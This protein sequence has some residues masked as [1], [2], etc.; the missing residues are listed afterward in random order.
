MSKITPN[1]ILIKA[2]GSYKKNFNQ[3]LSKQKFFNE[4]ALKEDT[5]KF[6]LLEIETKGPWHG[7]K[8]MQISASKMFTI[9][10][11]STTS[12][13]KITERNTVV[14]I[15][16]TYKIADKEL[17]TFLELLQ[18]SQITK[19]QKA[20]QAILDKTQVDLI[21]KRNN[22]TYNFQD[23]NIRNAQLPL[24]NY[25]EELEKR[26]INKPED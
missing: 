2:H 7:Y 9:I 6:E 8:K 21:Y 15:K 11:D 18:N 25:L 26:Y 14:P 5:T 19:V 20:S 13:S 12:M 24:I 4:A 3:N 23:I 22:H 10:I 1:Y 17:D 16:K